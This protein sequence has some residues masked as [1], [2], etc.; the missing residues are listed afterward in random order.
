[1]QDDGQRPE[2]ERKADRGEE[3]DSR[4]THLASVTCTTISL[5]SNARVYLGAA[6][7]CYLSRMNSHV[8]FEGAFS[9]Q[10]EEAP[11]LLYSGSG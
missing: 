2:R 11:S 9:I 6:Q 10:K 7:A 5:A 8:N 4:D 1:M 3:L